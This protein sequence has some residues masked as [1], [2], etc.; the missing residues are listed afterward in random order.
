MYLD[1]L[2]VGVQRALAVAARSSIA[3]VDGGIGGL[4]EHCPAA[5]RSD[6][7][8]IGGEGAYLHSGKVLRG[9]AA[10]HAVV[11]YGG[12]ELPANE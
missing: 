8:R 10:A 11:G 9:H 6:D 7:H 3:S 12:N 2:A 4:A 5:A 1:E